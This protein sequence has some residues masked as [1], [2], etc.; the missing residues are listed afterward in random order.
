MTDQ[1][2]T[3]LMMCPKLTCRKI[4]SVPE[5][6]RGKSIRCRNCG[7]IAKVPQN[8]QPEAKDKAAG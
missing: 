5:A 4:L 7:T 3:I 8:A 6:A 2:K 1:S